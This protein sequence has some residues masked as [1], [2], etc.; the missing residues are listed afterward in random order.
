M[1]GYLWPCAI[2]ITSAPHLGASDCAPT[3]NCDAPAYCPPTC[4]G[5]P[6]PESTDIKPENGQYVRGPESGEFVGPAESIGV[7]GFG[8]R[9]PEIRI[10]FPEIR[11]PHLVRYRRNPEMVV[12]E[13]RAPFVRGEALEFNQVNPESAPAPEST[14]KPEPEAAPY[15]VPP[16]PSCTARERQLQ[17][18]LATREAEIHEM[19]QRFSQL[20]RMVTKLAERELAQQERGAR[21]VAAQEPEI[22]P[23]AYER[24]APT[25]RLMNAARPAP[26]VARQEVPVRAT[27]RTTVSARSTAAEGGFGDWNQAPAPVESAE[28]SVLGVELRSPFE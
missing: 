1:R 23:S 9:L 11:L 21:E 16:T 4:A 6:N 22:L 19:N 24:P 26:Q 15:C 7:R 12:T 2:L 27:R 20:E 17:M 13:S 18:E 8:F 28:P 25:T 5:K 10:D 3:P 14:D